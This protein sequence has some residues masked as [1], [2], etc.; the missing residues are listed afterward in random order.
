MDE[1]RAAPPVYVLDAWRAE[2]AR[3][4]VFIGSGAIAY[5][6]DVIAFM[7]GARLIDAPLVAP[8]VAELGEL[9]AALDGARLSTRLRPVYVRRPDASLHADQL[10]RLASADLV[11]DAC[12]A[13]RRRTA[14]RSRRSP[15]ASSQSTPNRSCA[16]GLGNGTRPGLDNPAVTRIFVIRTLDCPVAGY[17]ATWFLLPEV[18]INNLA[19]DLRSGGVVWPTHLLGCVLHTALDAR[20][21]RATLEVR[22]SNHAARRL[23]KASGFVCGSCGPTTTRT[24][25][26]MH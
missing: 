19:I 26:R 2:G 22:R 14:A 13:P 15:R 9:R 17:C 12:D 23:T 16:P 7:P 18:H 1:P 11:S 10:R 8:L 25:S 3:P 4:D 20:G 6:Q 24:R 21:E 5:G